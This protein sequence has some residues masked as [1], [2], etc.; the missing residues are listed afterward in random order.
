MPGTS[1]PA[2]ATFGSFSSNATTTTDGDTVTVHARSEMS[3]LN[4]LGLLKIGS[5]ITDVTATSDGSAVQLSGGTVVSGGSMLG[6]PIDI[7]ADGVR[8]APGTTTTTN[9]L[10]GLLG[11]L[12]VPAAGSLNDVLRSAGLHITVA[13]PVQNGSGSAGLL[14]AAGLRIDFE[15]SDRTFPVLG[16]LLDSI[17][18]T[19]PLAPGAPT[20]GDILALAGAR[21][22]VA[23]AVGRGVVSLS[24]TESKPFTITA[25][26]G[27]SAG[28]AG[29]APVAGSSPS[30]GARPGPAAAPA[31]IDAAPAPAVLDDTPAAASLGA[32]VGALALLVLLAQPFA[33]S[34]LAR[35]SAALLASNTASSCPWEGR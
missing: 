22:L 21:H 5:V 30:I 33:G 9:A 2:I 3:D 10:S 16:Q 28:G 11:G 24:A 17:P 14:Q 8:A 7:D 12:L 19:P 29:G 31:L 35:G 32:G 20:V 18:E 1:T 15:L 6:T 26:S 27:A 4:V 25:P 34:W 13:G 23:I